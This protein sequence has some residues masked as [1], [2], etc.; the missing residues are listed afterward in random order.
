[1]SLQVVFPPL[2]GMF[3]PIIHLPLSGAATLNLAVEQPVNG[4]S[5]ALFLS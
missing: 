2:H 1:M 4:L 3:S 5:F